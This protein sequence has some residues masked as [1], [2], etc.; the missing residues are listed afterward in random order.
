MENAL[1]T[2]RNNAF[3]PKK[4]QQNCIDTL[5]TKDVILN[6]WCRQAGKTTTNINIINKTVEQPNRCVLVVTNSLKECDIFIDSVYRSIDYSRVDYRT[7]DI[8]FLK[9]NSSI[10]A[11]P[12]LSTTLNS[13]VSKADLIIIGE[14]EW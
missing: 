5:T 11:S 9:N 1:D 14:F 6:W 8:I 3:I 4:Y 2:I 7:K 12:L 13:L 10:V